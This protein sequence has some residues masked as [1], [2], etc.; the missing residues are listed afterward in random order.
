M[1]EDEYNDNDANTSSNNNKGF[2]L[3][4]GPNTNANLLLPR[5][6]TVV[7]QQQQ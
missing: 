5:Q 3:Y 1:M 4:T 2:V 6:T 7:I